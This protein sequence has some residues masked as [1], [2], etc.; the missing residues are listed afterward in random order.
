V[1]TKIRLGTLVTGVIY[2]HPS[3][4]A[5]I[6]ATLDVLSGGRLFLGLGA[7]W[8][9]EE[10]MAYGIPFPSTGARFLMLEEALQ[11]IRICGIKNSR[12]LRMMGGFIR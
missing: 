11:L 6:G 8:N 10:S 1:T 9:E 12:L 5:K 4:L 2:R 3:V 7:A